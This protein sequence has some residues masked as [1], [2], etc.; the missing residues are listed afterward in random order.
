MEASLDLSRWGETPRGVGYRRWTMIS[1][2]LRQLLRLRLFKFLLAA[3]WSGGA[4]LAALG[5]LFSQSIATGGWLASLAEFLGPRAEAMASV[6]GAFI[7]LYPDICIGGWFTLIFWLHSFLGLL[8]SLVALTAMVPRLI[9]RDRATNALTVYLS[10]PLTSG[11][12][13]AGKL[14][15]I[16]GVLVLMW[17]GP[18]LFGWLLS[19]AFAPSSDFIVHSIPPL[20][21]ALAFHGIALVT[22]AAITLG[23]SAISRTSRTTT[24]LWMG[25]WLVLG[26]VAKPPGAP[27]WLRRA[28]FTYNLEQVRQGTF[29]LDQALTLASDTLPLLDQRVAQNFRGAADKVQ[30]KGYAGALASLAGFVLLGS[31]VFL[32]RL[33]PE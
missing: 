8:L 20:G 19:V 23:V 33:R 16:V 5:F 27:E 6:L 26:A 4:V 15:M 32:R 17:T 22:L 25:L 14:G 31:F 10:R 24:V 11:D 9:T 7:L 13:L 12:Y 30:P 1:T 18:L 28:S 21:H 2:G 29:R 3:A